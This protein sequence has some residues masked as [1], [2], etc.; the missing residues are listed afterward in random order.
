MKVGAVAAPV[1]VV[2]L[3]FTLVWAISI[4]TLKSGVTA[5]GSGLELV[6]LQLR[7]ARMQEEV[8]HL[9]QQRL[10]QQLAELDVLA[11]RAAQVSP[12]TAARN[13]PGAETFETD[14]NR[15]TGPRREWPRLEPQSG[16]AKTPD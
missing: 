7:V 1:I 4:A 10:E 12:E 2:V 6:R 13:D 8:L 9:S 3:V 5:V 15:A 16:P 14:G 11:A